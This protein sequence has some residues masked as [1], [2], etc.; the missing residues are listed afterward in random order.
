MIELTYFM[1]CDRFMCWSFDVCSFIIG[2]GVSVIIIGLLK[3]KKIKRAKD[4][5]A[6]NNERL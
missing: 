4:L 2:I 1:G 5:E 6:K 3:F